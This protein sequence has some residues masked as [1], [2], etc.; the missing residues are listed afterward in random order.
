[1]SDP[2]QIIPISVGTIA[3]KNRFP[4]AEAVENGFI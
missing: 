2:L 1:M 4:A 3:N